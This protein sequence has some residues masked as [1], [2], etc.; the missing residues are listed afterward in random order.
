MSLPFSPDV[1][2]QQDQQEQMVV[3]GF[4]ASLPSKYDIAKSQI[5]SSH[6]ISSLQ[7]TFSTIHCIENPPPAQLNGAFFSRNNNELGK[8]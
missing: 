1:K 8:Q 3:M 5:L 2:V 6:E 4:R 7:D